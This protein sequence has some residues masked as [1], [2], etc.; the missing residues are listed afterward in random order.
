MTNRWPSQVGEVVSTQHCRLSANSVFCRC[1]DTLWGNAYLVTAWDLP[2]V[3]LVYVQFTRSGAMAWPTSLHLSQGICWIVLHWRVGAPHL[4]CRHTPFNMRSGTSP[5]HNHMKAGSALLVKGQCWLEETAVSRPCLTHV[6]NKVDAS[7]SI[8]T[9]LLSPEKSVTTAG[10]RAVSI[11]DLL[12]IRA[13][14]CKLMRWFRRLCCG[15]PRAWSTPHY[16]W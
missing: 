8:G 12:Q 2:A 3:D 16:C 10:F 7:S 9:A 6:S 13:L 11:R 1:C 14:A 4:R 5:G 15:A